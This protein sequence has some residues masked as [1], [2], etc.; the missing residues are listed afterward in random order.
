MLSVVTKHPSPLN[1]VVSLL[2]CA[3]VVLGGGAIFHSQRALA[4]DAGSVFRAQI[5]HGLSVRPPQATAAATDIAKRMIS[6]I[7]PLA[8][9]GSSSRVRESSRT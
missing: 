7:H 8:D 1:G 3:H 6:L 9:C 2:G 5:A 4:H